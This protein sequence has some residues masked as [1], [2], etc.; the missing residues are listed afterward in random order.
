MAAARTRTVALAVVAPIRRLVCAMGDV[1]EGR[2][3]LTLRL[4]ESVLRFLTV[5]ANPE[6]ESN[7]LKVRIAEV[8]SQ[9]GWSVG[10]GEGHL[11]QGFEVKGERIVRAA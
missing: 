4:D 11:P 8:F 1:A 9:R 7:R 10:E 5:L 6:E 2:R 3:D